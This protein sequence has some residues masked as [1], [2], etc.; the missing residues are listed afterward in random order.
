[1]SKAP[2]ITQQTHLMREEE[3]IRK[4]KAGTTATRQIIKMGRGQEG[5]TG[6]SGKSM[7][8]TLIG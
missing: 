2:D 4:K 5:L 3:T 6:Q 1:M 8:E 7:L